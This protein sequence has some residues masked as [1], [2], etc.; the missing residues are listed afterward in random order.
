MRLLAGRT[1]ATNRLIPRSRAARRE[2]LEQHRT[3]P[4]SLHVVADQER[5]LRTP[6]AERVESPDTDDVVPVERE[7]GHP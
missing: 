4:Q 3:Q 2:V 7:E 1:S 6:V 5:D